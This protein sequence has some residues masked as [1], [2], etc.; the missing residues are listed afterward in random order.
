MAICEGACYTVQQEARHC[1]NCGHLASPTA[2]HCEAC[3]A[4]LDGTPTATVIEVTGNGANVVDPRDVSDTADTA[5]AGRDPST[6]RIDD[7]PFFRSYRFGDA[8]DRGFRGNVVVARSGGRACL[9]A[10]IVSLVCLVLLCMF[11]GWL[12]GLV[13]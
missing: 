1:P 2:R 11:L 8:R 10:L 6:V 5:G 13:F 7:G 9:I 3:G 4:A 12:V